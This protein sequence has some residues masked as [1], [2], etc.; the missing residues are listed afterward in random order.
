M[1]YSQRGF[2]VAVPGFDPQFLDKGRL[3]FRVRGELLLLVTSNLASTTGLSRLLHHQ[4]EEHEI[5]H[6]TKAFM[7]HVRVK[8]YLKSN[9]EII[10][11]DTVEPPKNKGSFPFM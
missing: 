8:K 5:N 11:G 4:L 1:K 6:V 2:G 9:G 10:K 7:Y 3:K